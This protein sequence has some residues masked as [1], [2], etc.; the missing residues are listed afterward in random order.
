M[1]SPTNRL[2]VVATFSLLGSLA[3][4]AEA[5]TP[6]HFPDQGPRTVSTVNGKEVWQLGTT[7]HRGNMSS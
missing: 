7:T 6:A 2:V 5:Q 4:L 1:S 3:L